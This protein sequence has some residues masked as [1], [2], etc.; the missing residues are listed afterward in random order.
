[1][2]K[3]W[4]LLPA[5]LLL[6]CAASGCARKAA[7]PA[8]DL[9]RAALDSQIYTEEMTELSRSRTDALLDLSDGDAVEA[10]MLMDASRS[11]PEMIAVLTCAN[12]TSAASA[13]RK[14]GE[15]LESLRAQYAD[16]RPEEMPK[17]EA[18]SVMKYGS[19]CVLVVAPD[20]EAA[21][22]AVSK[23]WGK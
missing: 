11:T 13:E 6:L 7:P 9:A 18:A 23:A 10:V 15:Y 17:L 19:Q 21:R 20:Q 8:A 16:Y 4:L 5:L 14:L 22:S 12:G 2:K 1:M 3:H